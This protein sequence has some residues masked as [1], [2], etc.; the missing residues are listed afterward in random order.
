MHQHMTGGLG[1]RQ[2]ANVH[3]QKAH[4]MLPTVCC[5]PCDSFAAALELHGEAGQKTI[6]GLL[7]RSFGVRLTDEIPGWHNLA[8]DAAARNFKGIKEY[9]TKW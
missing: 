8:S 2:C 3:N 5:Q 4:D 6:L 1:A 9:Q 7:L